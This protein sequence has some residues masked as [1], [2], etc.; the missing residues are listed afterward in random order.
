M[1]MVWKGMEIVWKRVEIV[2]TLSGSMLGLNESAL[3]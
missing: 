3:R 2:W 1:E